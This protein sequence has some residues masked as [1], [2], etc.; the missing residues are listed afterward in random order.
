MVKEFGS[1]CGRYVATALKETAGE[2]G[3]RVGMGLDD[4]DEHLGECNFLGHRVRVRGR[5]QLDGPQRLLIV[6]VDC[7]HVLV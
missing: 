1:F 3:D 5:K 4:V 6:V 2:N 7:G